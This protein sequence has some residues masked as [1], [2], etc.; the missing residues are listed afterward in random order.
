MNKKKIKDKD[1][2][3]LVEGED[4]DKKLE[5]VEKYKLLNE[6]VAKEKEEK[7]KQEEYA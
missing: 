3:K 4:L 5:K 1:L 7:R 2:R 6:M